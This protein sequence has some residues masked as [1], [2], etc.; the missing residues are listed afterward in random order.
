[1]LFFLQKLGGL[2]DKERAAREHSYA[3]I[4]SDTIKCSP[5]LIFAFLTV[6]KWRQGE[7]KI[8]K[9][10]LWVKPNNVFLIGS[11]VFIEEQ[12]VLIQAK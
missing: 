9:L 1:M 6:H 4:I 8:W 3:Q 2:P 12:T 10:I 7:L 11:D 5:L